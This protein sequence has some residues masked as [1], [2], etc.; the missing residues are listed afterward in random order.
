MNNFR[1]SHEALSYIHVIIRV[2]SNLVQDAVELF[3]EV[4]SLKSVKNPSLSQISNMEDKEELLD[5][6]V[7]RMDVYERSEYRKTLKNRK[8]DLAS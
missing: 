3:K 6:I 2:M 8:K 7:G 1:A 4:E 5:Y